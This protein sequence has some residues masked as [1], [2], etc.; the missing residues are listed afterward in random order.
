MITRQKR[1]YLVNYPAR[2]KVF[3]QLIS[4]LRALFR[5]VMRQDNLG[6]SVEDMENQLQDQVDSLEQR[7]AFV[8]IGG[9]AG[10]TEMEFILAQVIPQPRD[11][12]FDF[13]HCSAHLD[14][15]PV[16]GLGAEWC[17]G[18]RWRPDGGDGHHGR[19]GRPSV[20]RRWQPS[21]V[22]SQRGCYV[23]LSF[24]VT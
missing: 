22:G 24:V 7:D 4:G 6:R 1:K 15:R 17:H 5:D 18:R 9:V 16:N 21:R 14:I 10:N 23:R 8:D 3:L 12:G 11:E 13:A 19:T 2:E 20:P